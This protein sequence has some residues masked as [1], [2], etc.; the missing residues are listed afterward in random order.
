MGLLLPLLPFVV[1]K[2]LV[3]P[4]LSSLLAQLWRLLNAFVVAIEL[5]FEPGDFLL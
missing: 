4:V 5:I 2:S 3:A 1:Q